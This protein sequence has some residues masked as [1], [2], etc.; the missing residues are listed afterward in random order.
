MI[1]GRRPRECATTFVKDTSGAVLI[2][3]SVLLLIIFAMIGLAIDGSRYLYLGSN[4]K[5]VADAAALAAAKELNGAK[6]AITRAQNAALD[7]T[8]VGYVDNHPQSAWAFGTAPAVEIASVSVCSALGAVGSDCVVTTD[9]QKAAYVRVVTKSRGFTTSFIGAVTGASTAN[10]QREST[11]ATSYSVCGPLQSF[12]CNPWEDAISP[13]AGKNWTENMPVGTMTKLVDGTGSASGNWGLLDPG[14]KGGNNVVLPPFWAQN[15]AS[16]CTQ[17]NVSDLFRDVETGNLAKFAEPGMNVRFDSPISSGDGSLSG[18]IVIDGLTKTGNNYN[19]ANTVS[20]TPTSN[21]YTF[22]QPTSNSDQTYENYC[23][24]A[25]PNSASCPFPRDR[26]FTNVTRTTAANGDSYQNIIKGNQV[27]AADLAAYWTNHHGGSLPAGVAT[28][29]DAYQYEV[30]N[31]PSWLTDTAEP[32]APA[33][34]NSTVGDKWRRVL[35]VAIVDCKYWGIHGTSNPVPMT[36]LI[37]K[38]FMTEPA[39]RSPV[40]DQGTIYGELIGT[41]NV[42]QSGG[43]IYQ[44]VVLV[45]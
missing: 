20:A 18:P 16:S 10:S 40:Q 9:P 13:G 41:F 37:A 38:F 26:Q 5:A 14:G 25:N 33:C 11:A 19:C 1:L 6:D 2:W 29:W 12:M 44:N 34:T 32:H 35:N 17:A 8:T 15:S 43:V 28:R 31:S 7:S 30:E 42:N 4:M 45:R 22:A 24:F 23:K 27:N 36:T 21:G 39:V 3:V